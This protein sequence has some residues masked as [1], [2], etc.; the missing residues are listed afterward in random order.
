MSLIERLFP[1]LALKAYQRRIA[2]EQAKRTYTAAQDSRLRKRPTVNQS[3]DAA[4]TAAGE[5][6]RL[7]ARHL[8]ENSDLAVGVL[9][10]LV[11]NIIGTGLTIEPMA[12]Q[13]NGKP[14]ERINKQ[15]REAFTTWAKRP[16]VTGE[17]PFGEVQRLACRSWLRDGEVLAQHVEGTGKLDHLGGVPY[18]IELIE[19]DYLPMDLYDQ[20]RGIIH[21]VEKNAWG[22]PRAYHLYK[23]HPGNATVGYYLP[24]DRNTKRVSADQILHVKFCRRIKQTRGVTVFHSV[25]TRMD[26]LKDYEESERIAARVAAAFTGYI[27]KSP[28]LST[29]TNSDGDR[30]FEMAPGLIFDNLLPGEEVG[31]VASNRP[32]AG[33]QDFRN[34]MLRAVA[35]GTGASYSS[36]SKDYNGTY[37][38]Q[39]QEL[40]E[41]M[42]GY[43]RMREYFIASFLRPVY[44]HFVDMA[45]M[46]GAVTVP[47]TMTQEQLYNADYGGVAMPWIDP[48]KEVEADALKIEAGLASRYQVIRERGGDPRMVDEQRKQDTDAPAM[49]QDKPA[50]KEKPADTDEE[51]A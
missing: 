7:W 25:I 43:R 36:I 15:L 41:S 19:A 29:T 38:A 22:R 47:P 31:T 27:K 28:D 16:E 17:L 10:T 39:R 42:P 30:T 35:A 14:A 5:K 26:D 23:E 50:A 44:E 51:A 18:S 9:D 37:S 8:D 3:G 2:L 24:N 33:L 20:D 12:M 34:A 49:E 6:L 11:Q 45:V 13:K 46:S 40:V 1:G 32:N 4:I 48:K 21:G